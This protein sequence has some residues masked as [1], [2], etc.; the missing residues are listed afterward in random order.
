MPSIT[1]KDLIKFAEVIIKIGINLQPGQRL[2]VGPPSLNPG[3]PL[4]A[5]P[6]IREIT[7]QAYQAGARLVTVLWRDDQLRLARFKHAPR[8]SFEEYDTWMAEGYRQHVEAGDAVLTIM[9]NDPDLFTGQDPE[10]VALT[11]KTALIQTKPARDFI[12]GNA[13][14]WTIASYPA[15]KWATKVYPNLPEAEAVDTLWGDIL[16]I[17]RIDQPDPVAA[18]HEHIRQLSARGQ[19]MGDKQYTALKFTGPGTDLTIGLPKGH[20]WLS[21]GFESQAGI[22]YTANIPTEEIFTLPDRTRADGVVT[23]TKPL[24]YGGAFIDDF[25]VSFE[26]GRVSKIVAKTGEDVLRKMSENDEGASRLGEVALVPNSSPISQSGL[27][28]YNTLYDENASNHIALGQGYRPTIQGGEQMNNEQFEAA[29]GN[30]SLIHTDFMIG[31]G[32]MDVDGIHD[33]GSTEPVMRGGEWA[34]DA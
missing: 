28:F 2:L 18:W 7:T 11:Q 33:D 13:I 23:A 1:Q 24:I 34:F 32:E 12:S 19:Y 22:A 20:K 26:N 14:N 17:C 5:A 21:A 6:L 10:L 29:G 4:E 31:S 16:K 15:A 27:L 3:T 8:D 25:S 9:A 30:N